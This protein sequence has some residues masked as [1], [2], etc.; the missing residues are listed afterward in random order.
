MAPARQRLG[1]HVPGVTLPTT[2]R[3]LKA[4]IVKS[5]QTSITR[6]QLAGARLPWNYI[7]FRYNAYMKNSSRTLEGDDFYPVLPKL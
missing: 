4:G 2:E 6:Q 5:E 7:R 3:R 1:K